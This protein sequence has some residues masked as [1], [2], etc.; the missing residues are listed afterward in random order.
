MVLASTCGNLAGCESQAGLVRSAR[1]EA[2]PGSNTIEG[3]DARL[4]DAAAIGPDDAHP[5][6]GIGAAMDQP[7]TRSPTEAQVPGTCYS[8]RTGSGARWTPGSLRVL[9]G[10]T[11]ET[12]RFGSVRFGPDSGATLS[13]TNN[14]R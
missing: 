8:V 10:A 12:H 7:P 3:Y 1:S 13:T 14:G 11:T 5:H 6:Q 9:T 4:D 2:D